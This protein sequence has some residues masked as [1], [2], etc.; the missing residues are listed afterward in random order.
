LEFLADGASLY[1]GDEVYTSGSDG[2]LP[3]G[4]RV[5]TVTGA[6]GAFKVRPHVEFSSLDA[7]SVVFFD[8]PALVSVDPPRAISPKPLSSVPTA[9]DTDAE[10][11]APV[12]TATANSPSE[13][14][15]QQ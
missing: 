13:V 5:G 1:A 2:V 11:M 7:V 4:L 8:S 14:G 9:L 15:S 6:S 3:R 10:E 12:S